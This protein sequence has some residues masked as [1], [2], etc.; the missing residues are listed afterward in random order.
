MLGDHC[1]N[2]SVHPK[3]GKDRCNG[4]FYRFLGTH[5]EEEARVTKRRRAQEACFLKVEGVP[6]KLMDS[7]LFRN[8]G[9][10]RIAQELPHIRQWDSGRNEGE[11]PGKVLQIK[12][13]LLD[14]ISKNILSERPRH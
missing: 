7:F 5:S 6:K 9:P 8:K 14:V 4:H 12:G 11:A 13:I 10:F 2:L 1:T 3:A